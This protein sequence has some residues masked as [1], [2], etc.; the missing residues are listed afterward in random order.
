MPPQKRFGES[1]VRS[2]KITEEQ[3]QEA[4]QKQKTD[5]GRL[6]AVLMKMGHLDEPELV[7]ALSRHFGVPSV[8]LDGVEIDEAI[9]KIIPS[10]IA[11]KYTILPV[12]K[13]GA[14]VTLAMLDP[15]NVFAMDD[16]KFMTGYRV[17]PVVAAED[18]IKSAIDQYYGSTHAIELKK[19][20][21]EVSEDA[22]TDL[23]VLEEEE[24]L[25]LDTLEQ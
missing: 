16:V 8:D 11:R 5:G 3:L 23:E 7:E 14:T 1:L 15:T 4:L 20:M 24:D 9:L 21:E 13:A 22:E 10:D 25:D 19:V 2:G 18:Q 6:G 12:S 17:E